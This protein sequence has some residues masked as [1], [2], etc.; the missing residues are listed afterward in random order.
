MKLF[1]STFVFTEHQIS[2]TKGLRKDSFLASQINLLFKK[3]LRST[4][5]KRSPKCFFQGELMFLL[6]DVEAA[7]LTINVSFSF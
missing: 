6:L 4:K 3:S 1:S 5:P 7:T 2:H